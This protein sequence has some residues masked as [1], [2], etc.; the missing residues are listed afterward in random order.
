[1]WAKKNYLRELNILTIFRVKPGDNPCLQERFL[2]RSLLQVRSTMSKLTKSGLNEVE[3]GPG[4]WQCYHASKPSGSKQT[5]V[6][7]I[8]P[9]TGGQLTR[10]T[11]SSE[12]SLVDDLQPFHGGMSLVWAQPPSA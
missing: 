5:P 10:V 7:V 4:F 3:A 8:G 2:H 11:D 1:M 9:K 6:W 12:G